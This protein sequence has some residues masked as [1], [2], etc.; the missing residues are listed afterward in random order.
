[1]CSDFCA[2][3][4]LPH[5]HTAGVP[6]AENNNGEGDDEDSPVE[7]NVLGHLLGHVSLAQTCGMLMFLSLGSACL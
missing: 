6:P 4:M 7:E 2:H 1:M 5:V 3:G